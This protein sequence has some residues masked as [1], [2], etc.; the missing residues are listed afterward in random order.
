MAMSSP[1]HPI[2]QIVRHVT[3][4]QIVR[5]AMEKSVGGYS[6]DVHVDNVCAIREPTWRVAV[7]DV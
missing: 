1:V 5:K 3:K 7:D 4:T 2:A 6:T